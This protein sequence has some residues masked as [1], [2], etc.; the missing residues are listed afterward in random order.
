VAGGAATILNA[1]RAGSRRRTQAR[2][3]AW[4]ASRGELADH[5]PLDDLPPSDEGV[6][7]LGPMTDP[8][9]RGDYELQ[10][11]PWDGDPPHLLAVASTGGGKS[12]L[13]KGPLLGYPLL[14]NEER[15]RQGLPELFQVDVI[16]LKE[17]SEF[18]PLPIAGT[19]TEAAALLRDLREDLRRRAHLLRDV[20]R[21]VH[22]PTTGKTVPG[23]PRTFREIPEDLR[24]GLPI[25]VVLID[26][27]SLLNQPKPPTLGSREKP[28]QAHQAA[29]AAHRAGVEAITLLREITAL[30]RSLGIHI[31]ILIQRPDADL[32]PGFLKNNVQAR[33][34][35]GENDLEAQVM[36]L[37]DA[38]ASEAILES[39]PTHRPPGRMVAAAV[40]GPGARLA[41]AYHIHE[42][43]FL[44][45]AHD[46]GGPASPPPPAPATAGPPEG[47]AQDGRG[48]DGSPGG[49][50]GGDHG[51]LPAGIRVGGRNFVPPPPD[52]AVTAASPPPTPPARVAPLHRSVRGV[53][54]RAF[55]RATAWRLLAGPLVENPPGRPTGLRQAVLTR[56]GHRCAACGAREGP[57]HVDHWRPRKAGGSDR[58]RN[59]WVLCLRCHGAKTSEEATVLKWRRRL[60][61]RVLRR[62]PWWAWPLTGLFCLGV[63]ASQRMAGVWLLGLLA[64]A[65]GAAQAVMV[66]VQRSGLDGLNTL[67]ARLE[68]SY[69]GVVAAASRTRTAVFLT[70]NMVRLQLGLGS[71]AFLAGAA[72]GWWW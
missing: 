38:R 22:D 29:V 21:H 33:V 9:P 68:E 34:L 40:G 32:L 65:F 35:L 39:D 28:T 3:R 44:R 24:A 72:A 20:P 11:R 7:R 31:F 53:A 15:R 17:A 18:W 70:V 8:G 41:Q 55:L 52:P 61:L 23:R 43:A 45:R 63:V 71:V 69:G 10:Y 30:G 50:V 51:Y 12:E 46:A 57:L 1:R 58:M 6:W 19:P 4:R 14:W 25:R 37:G 36:T 54:A 26:E 59:L 13:A 27:A 66:L 48:A 42:A 5:Y 60:T 47:A 62:P 67:D 64:A 2:L 56:R 16:D 49:G